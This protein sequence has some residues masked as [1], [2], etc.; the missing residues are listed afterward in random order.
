MAS[1]QNRIVGALQLKPATFEEVENDA[2]ATSQAAM[3]VVAAAVS[4]GLANF[5]FFGVTWFVASIC[6]ALVAWAIGSW[7]LLMVGTKIMPGKNTQA[8]LG[9]MLRVMGFAS[10]PGLFGIISVIPFLG[11]LVALVL[12][13]WSIAASVIGVR[14]ALD[15]DDTVKAIIVCVIAWVIM[16]VVMMLLGLFGLGAATLGSGAGLGS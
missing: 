3:I 6:M 11:I 13:L 9:Q 15:Y 8:D 2:T 5:R 7:V 14:Q 4:R 1:L 10:A 12:G 16:F